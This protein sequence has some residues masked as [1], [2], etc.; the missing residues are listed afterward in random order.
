MAMRLSDLQ[1]SVRHCTYTQRKYGRAIVVFH[2][3]AEPTLPKTTL[4]S[5]QNEHH[6]SSWG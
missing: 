3:Y 6:S 2:G 5:A 4:E 1:G